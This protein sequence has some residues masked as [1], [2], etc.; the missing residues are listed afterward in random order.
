MKK[1]LFCIMMIF[2]LF[3]LYSMTKNTEST[4]LKGYIIA[5]GHEPFVYPVIRTLE[6]EDYSIEATDDLKQKLL[7]TQGVLL[8]MSGQIIPNE[9]EDIPEQGAKNGFIKLK[10]WKTKN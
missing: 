6:G 7:K 2:N 3:S 8:E 5:A 9:T 1:R 10:K 4:T